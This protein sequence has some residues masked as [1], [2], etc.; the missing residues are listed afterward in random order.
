MLLRHIGHNIKTTL[1]VTR[2]YCHGKSLLLVFMWVLAVSSLGL[3][4]SMNV[5]L[6]CSQCFVICSVIFRLN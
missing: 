3:W 6:V 4:G 2:P 5:L 1:S